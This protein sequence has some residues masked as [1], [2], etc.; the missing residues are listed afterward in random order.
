MYGVEFCG[1]VFGCMFSIFRCMISECTSKGGVL[2]DAFSTS[3]YESY[4]GRAGKR[5]MTDSFN[6][7]V[8][9]LENID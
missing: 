9:D 7:R 3:A 1:T 8:T 5:S 4:R 2:L 6:H